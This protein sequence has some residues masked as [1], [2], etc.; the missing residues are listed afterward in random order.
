MR[1]FIYSRG[2]G[3]D[4]LTFRCLQFYKFT[5]CISKAKEWLWWQRSGIPARTAAQTAPGAVAP[6]TL[7][8]CS[9]SPKLCTVCVLQTS[10]P[11]WTFPTSVEQFTHLWSHISSACLGCE[12]KLTSSAVSWSVF[13]FLFRNN[14]VAASIT[15]RLKKLDITTTFITLECL[16]VM[17]FCKV[18]ITFVGV[19]FFFY[20]YV[21][22]RSNTSLLVVLV[23]LIR[24]VPVWNSIM[25]Q[26]GLFQI[27]HRLFFFLAA[28]LSS[29]RI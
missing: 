4:Q 19:L 23:V 8:K 14:I 27:S 5:N 18:G 26:T 10:C 13:S 3:S 15:Q 6:C 29:L 21:F 2:W 17:C 9:K 1:R 25:C 12:R 16:L 7:P 11:A 24:G 22:D 20:F 28:V